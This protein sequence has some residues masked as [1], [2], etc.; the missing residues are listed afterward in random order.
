[1][2][3]HRD[4]EPIFLAG[5]IPAPKGAYSPVVRAGD[6][7]YVSG[8]VPRDPV[9]GA[10]V[11][12]DVRAQTRQV[13]ANVRRALEAAGATLGDVV[14]VTAYLASSDLWTDFNDEFRTNMTAPYPR[15]TAHGA[16]L[17]GI[18]VEISVVAYK[19]QG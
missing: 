12:D 9:S 17:R 2:T 13:M 7:L 6:F 18:L 19:R 10:L 5:D 8:Q 14:S 16:E 1:V 15:R 3:Q 4:W 11:G